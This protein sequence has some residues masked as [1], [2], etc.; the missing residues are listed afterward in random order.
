MSNMK[1]FTEF[2]NTIHN[3]GTIALKMKYTF[4]GVKPMMIFYRKIWEDRKPNDGNDW[5]V[6]RSELTITR[7][8][9]VD[10][11]DHYDSIIGEEEE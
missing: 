3:D 11:I 8:T 1:V 9:Y 6:S 5:Q 7:T 2:G 4:E 10:A